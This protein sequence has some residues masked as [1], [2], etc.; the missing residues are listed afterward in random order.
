MGDKKIM[1]KKIILIIILLIVVVC[2]SVACATVLL[3]K[4]N[5]NATNITNNTTNNTV[6]VTHIGNNTESTGSSGSGNR[7]KVDSKVESDPEFG[8]DEYVAKWDES[9]RQG[10]S[11]AYRHK[12]PTKTEDGQA[13]HRVY[14]PDSGESYWAKGI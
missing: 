5:N 7:S 4:N 9:Q 14:N 13:Y 3:P 10:D 8:S 2:L 12:Q 1:D 11:W 6:N